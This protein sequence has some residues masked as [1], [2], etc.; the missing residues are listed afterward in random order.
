MVIKAGS[1]S[2]KVATMQEWAAEFKGRNESLEHD[3]RSGFPATATIEE[4]IIFI[5]W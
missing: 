2:P 4:S 3:Q 1:S 5:T